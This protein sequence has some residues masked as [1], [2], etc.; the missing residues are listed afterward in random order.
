MLAQLRIDLIINVE[1]TGIHN[2][3]IHTRRNGVIE[4]DR[5]HG[6]AHRLI[7]AEGEGHIRQTA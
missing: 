6:A 4:E 7:A 3:H 2:A 1:L 5:V